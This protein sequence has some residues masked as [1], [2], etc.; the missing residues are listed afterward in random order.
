MMQSRTHTCDALRLEDAGKNVT[1]CGWMENVRTVGQNFA[2]VVLRDFYGTTQVVVETEEMMNI[3]NGLKKVGKSARRNL[4]FLHFR[5]RYVLCGLVIAYH[6]FTQDFLFR[7]VKRIISTPAPLPLTG[8]Q[9][10]LLHLLCRGVRVP[11]PANV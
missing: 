4:R 2:F 5:A 8:A 11:C 3:I 9:R 1:L 6:T 7:M 10:S